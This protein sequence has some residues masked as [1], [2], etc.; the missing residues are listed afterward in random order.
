VESVPIERE[1]HMSMNEV[2]PPD[3]ATPFE[4]T[5][6]QDL[7]RRF[8]ILEQNQRDMLFLLRSLRHALH[9]G[10]VEL[11]PETRR[12]HRE[13]IRME[14][15]NGVCPCCLETK[16]L[17]EDGAFISPVEFDHFWGPAYSAPVHSW[18]I[19]R[20]CHQDLTNDRHLTWYARLTTRFRLYQAATEAYTA[21]FS[22]RTP[23]RMH[24]SKRKP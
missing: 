18:L 3:G 24:T 7:L 11:S 5:D 2:F 14:P 17:S 6:M 19:C 4:S 21:A 1:R 13:I 15:F 9:N 10:R 8:T 20:P 22:S 12:I 23:A 16:V